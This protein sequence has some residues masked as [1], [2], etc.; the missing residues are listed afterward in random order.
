MYVLID[1]PLFHPKAKTVSDEVLAG[2]V[3]KT[4][5]QRPSF[6][7]LLMLLLSSISEPC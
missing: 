7:C 2:L 6:Q 3:H 1:S 4:S 5:M